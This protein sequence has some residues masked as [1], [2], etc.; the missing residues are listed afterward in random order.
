[1]FLEVWA[2]S[3]E[4]AIIFLT[5]SRPD[6]STGPIVFNTSKNFLNPLAKVLMAFLSVSVRK[7]S[8]FTSFLSIPS[9]DDLDKT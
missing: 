9:P 2:P 4:S 1:M 5:S 6:K 3:W 7:T 8:P